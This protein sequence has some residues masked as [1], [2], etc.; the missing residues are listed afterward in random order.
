MQTPETRLS[1][2]V[3]LKNPNA[4]D[5]WTDFDA[6]YRP[7]VIRVA[8]AKGLQHA[9]AEDL[10]QEVLMTVRRTIESFERRGDGSFRSWLFRVTRNLVVNRLTR[11]SGPTG[12]GDS[13]VQKALSQQPADDDPT[14]TLFLLEYR[15]ARF[16][17]AAAKVKSQFALTTWQ[18]FWLTAI[19]EQPVDHV[20]RKL[21]KTPGA[22]RV[23][24]CRVI[25][26]LRD[27]VAIDDDSEILLRR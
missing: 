14:A 3:S 2:L 20:A 4:D 10:A 15:R 25:A 7:L 19:E 8:Q 27:E 1:L 9:D 23:A 16:K 11:T 5:A 13:K 26:R 18:A 24:R 6:L 12:S 21:G 17:Q 22:V